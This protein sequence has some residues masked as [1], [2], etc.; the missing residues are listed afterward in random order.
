MPFAIACDPHQIHHS[1]G[2][3]LHGHGARG[4]EGG[5]L[6]QG[7]GRGSRF[8]GH[9]QTLRVGNWEVKTD[10]ALEARDKDGA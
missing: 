1:F 8:D 6:R 5:R 7:R 10:R 2:G 9:L 3:A 4:S